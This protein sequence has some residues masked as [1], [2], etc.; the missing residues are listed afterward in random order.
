METINNMDNIEKNITISLEE[1]KEL[2][3]YKGRYLEM[4]ENQSQNIPYDPLIYPKYP[5]TVTYKD[6]RTGLSAPYEVK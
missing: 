6:E 3:E 5:T 1:Y 4:K 2:L